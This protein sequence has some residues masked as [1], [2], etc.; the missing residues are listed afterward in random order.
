MKHK[1]EISVQPNCR[2][3]EFPFYEIEPGSNEAFFV[4]VHDAGTNGQNIRYYAK[5]AGVKIKLRQRHKE[6]VM[7]YFVWVTSIDSNRVIT[8]PP[9]IQHAAE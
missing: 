8:P 4:P 1:Y 5:A 6:G 3:K 2:L 7:G 9:Q